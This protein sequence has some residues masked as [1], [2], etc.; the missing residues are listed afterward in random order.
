MRTT[1]AVRSGRASR[2]T[3]QAVACT[4]DT[5]AWRVQPRDPAPGRHLHER[6]AGGQFQAVGVADRLA[7]ISRCVGDRRA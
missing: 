4:P 7:P 2:H 1:N 6:H 5:F 3:R